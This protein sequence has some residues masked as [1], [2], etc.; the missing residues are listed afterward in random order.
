MCGLWCGVTDVETAGKGTP[1]YCNMCLRRDLITIEGINIGA[2]AR[3][4]PTRQK[5]SR[6]LPACLMISHSTP[7]TICIIVQ[8]NRQAPLAREQ[9][10]IS[11]SEESGQPN[12]SREKNIKRPLQKSHSWL[13]WYGCLPNRSKGPLKVE[14]NPLKIRLCRFSVKP[15]T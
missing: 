1:L 9:S 14:L 10:Q 13:V 12:M 5:R 11:S 15:E 7:C 6:P 8:M 4:F 3:D 2:A